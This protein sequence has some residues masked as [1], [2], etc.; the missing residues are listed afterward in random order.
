L[1]T[2]TLERDPDSAR[3]A[4]V[5]ITHGLNAAV[6]QV[7]GLA[8]QLHPP[9]LELLGLVEA[10]RERTQ[11]LPGLAIHLDAPAQLPRLHP[12]IETAAYYIALE[13]LTNIEKHAGARSCRLRLALADGDAALRPPMLELDIVDD[14]R[15]P[16]TDRPGGLGLLSMQARAAEVGGS[17]L[18]EADPR[19]GM[20]IA[21]R[22]PVEEP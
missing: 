10:L 8:H 11:M 20:R 15:G 21:V 22:L 18:V 13:A 17:C 1:A 2:R 4:L 12:A 9:E 7:R 19:G 3:A 5:D 16:A 14:G 6:A